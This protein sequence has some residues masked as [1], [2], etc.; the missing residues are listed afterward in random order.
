MGKQ[1]NRD[2]THTPTSTNELICM[3]IDIV[4]YSYVSKSAYLNQRRFMVNLT[5]PFPDTPIRIEYLRKSRYSYHLIISTVCL[6]R[7]D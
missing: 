6:E 7:N 2:S 4:T 3:L 5:S 1:Q